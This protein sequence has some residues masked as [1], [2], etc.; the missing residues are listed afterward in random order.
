MRVTVEV[1]LTVPLFFA[2]YVALD[3]VVPA[4]LL[5]A[6]VDVAAA[7]WT[8]AALKAEGLW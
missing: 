2:A 4:L 7:L 8:R 6:V 3:W 5:F 1:R